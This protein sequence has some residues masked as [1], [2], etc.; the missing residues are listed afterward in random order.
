M[1]S[2]VLLTLLEEEEIIL[3]VENN[4]AI[5]EVYLILQYSC[6]TTIRVIVLKIV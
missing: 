1:I 3:I 5:P 6:L 2:G 4:I